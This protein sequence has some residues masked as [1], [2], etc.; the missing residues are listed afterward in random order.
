MPRDLTRLVLV[1][2]LAGLVAACG[3]PRINDAGPAVNAPGNQPD[4]R[5]AGNQPAGPVAAPAISLQPVY[6]ADTRFRTTRTLRVEELTATERYLTE[7]TEV[8][9]TRVLSV[10]ERGRLLAVRRD[11]ELS[12]TRLT[13]GFGQGEAAPGILQGAILEL[14]RRQGAVQVEVLAGD[15]ALARQNFLMDGF[16]L[17]LLP[18]D[19]VRQGDR[20]VLDAGALAALNKFI[21]AVGYKI[22]KNKLTCVLARVT[23]DIAEISLDWQITG[24]FS[25]KPAVLGFEGSLVFDRRQKLVR[26]LAITG[27]RPTGDGVRQQIE[28]GLKRRLTKGWLD[29]DG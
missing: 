22:E 27:G 14:R 25:G 7:S 23:D 11:Y 4:N 12:N 8:T 6:A 17:A 15:S 9:L 10:D 13:K 16:E 26:E 5:P 21:E 1:V 29:L 3:N 18:L 28:I 20:W 24:E 2:S 19:D